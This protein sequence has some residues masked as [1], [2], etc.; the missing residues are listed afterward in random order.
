MHTEMPDVGNEVE[1]DLGGKKKKPLKHRG[2]FRF[3]LIFQEKLS[4]KK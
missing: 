1:M 2:A 3:V 4:E